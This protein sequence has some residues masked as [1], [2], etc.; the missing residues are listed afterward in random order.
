[1]N[2]DIKKLTVKF[3]NTIVGYLVEIE[4]GKIAFQYEGQWIINGFSIS[5]FSLPLSNK[6]FVSSSN[7]FDGLYGVFS[8][9]LPDG[10]GQLLTRRMLKNIGINFDK[11]T[12][13]TKLTLLSDNGLGG[14]SYEP[15]QYIGKDVSK[16]DI[17][18]IATDIKKLL[19]EKNEDFDLDQ[20]YKFGGSSGGARP[21]VHLQI[22]DGQWIIKFPL[23][24]DPINIGKTEFETNTLAKKS[25]INVNEFKLFPSSLTKGYFGAKRFDRVF[26]KRIHMISL[27]SLLETTHL[28]ANLD[29]V[30]FLQVIQKISVNKDD[31][32]EAYRRMCFN[33]LHQNKDDHGKNH[34][35][36]YDDNLKGYKLSPA[37]DITRTQ[38]KFEHEM[39][40]LG[41]G[42]PKEEDLINF[43]D[44][45]KLSKNKC[46]II[47][48]NVK[49]ALNT[50]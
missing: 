18:S 13:L 28:I 9:S 35:F 42:L 22:N 15:T 40:V 30:H 3:N 2:I 14:L 32:Y 29:Y 6:V 27:S 17:D 23:S 26:D 38:E 24:G 47:L 11:I 36:L 10:W 8:D 33:V 25:G 4:K 39:T 5:P 43:I 16:Y 19:E 44:E 12:P 37:F 41:N 45:M 31:V 48:D 21:K 1:V 20:L 34:A 46:L 49:K 50:R 7:N